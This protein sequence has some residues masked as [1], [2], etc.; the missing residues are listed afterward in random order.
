M[1]RNRLLTTAAGTL[2][3]TAI[4]GVAWASIPGR[5]NVYTACMLKGIGTIGKTDPT[6]LGSHR[7]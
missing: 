5:G 1:K 6:P 3:A 4:A 7:R 2:V